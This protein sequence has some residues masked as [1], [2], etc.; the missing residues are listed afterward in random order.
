MEELM[1]KKIKT[2]QEVRKVRK[3]K[4]GQHILPKATQARIATGLTIAAVKTTVKDSMTM[5]STMTN[6]TRRTMMVV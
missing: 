1:T 5:R 4:L 3:E 6:K 2:C